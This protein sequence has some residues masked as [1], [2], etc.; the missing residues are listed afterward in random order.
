MEKHRNHSLSLR[1]IQRTPLLRGFLY[2]PKFQGSNPRVPQSGTGF[3]KFVRNEFRMR[4]RLRSEPEGQSTG[5]YFVIPL[6]AK[7]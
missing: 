3:D 5:M 6:S 4:L 7:K 2:L 1:Q